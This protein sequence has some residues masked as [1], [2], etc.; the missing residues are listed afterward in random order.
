MTINN[1]VFVG[2]YVLV[3]DRVKWN[4]L[5]IIDLMIRQ[6]MPSYLPTKDAFFPYNINTSVT[7]LNNGLSKIRKWRFKWKL[8]FKPDPSK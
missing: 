4:I 7:H 8:S 6:Q 5:V 1:K 2:T 3:L